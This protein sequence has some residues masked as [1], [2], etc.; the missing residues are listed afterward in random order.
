MS[1]DDLTHLRPLGRVH[2]EMLRAFPALA[3]EW[4]GV[5]EAISSVGLW[6]HEN[7]DP[8]TARALLP[9]VE[10]T[11]ADAPREV[12]DA[13]DNLLRLDVLPLVGDERLGPLTT[14]RAATF[15]DGS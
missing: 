12:R 2:L 8:A 9:W 7:P 6:L 10:R 3:A 1:R 13:I 11:L 4:F 15:A 14:A 5:D